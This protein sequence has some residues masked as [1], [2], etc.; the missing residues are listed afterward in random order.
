MKATSGATPYNDLPLESIYETIHEAVI[1]LPAGGGYGLPTLFFSLQ[2]VGIGLCLV[3]FGLG[4]FLLA[5]DLAAGTRLA[6][7]VCG[8]RL[9]R[10]RPLN[11]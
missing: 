10:L 9:G 4:T 1:T 6:R 2:V 3:S 11:R 5:E 7:A 8:L